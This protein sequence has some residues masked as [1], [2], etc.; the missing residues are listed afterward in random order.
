MVYWID[1]SKDPRW[2]EFVNRHESSSVFHTPEWLRALQRTYGFTPLAITTSPPG[3]D[4]EDGIPFCRVRSFL[5]GTR[6]VSL[7]FTDHCQPL[8]APEEILQALPEHCRREKLKYVELRPLTA[9]DTSG[10]TASQRYYYH[11]LDLRPALNDIL[12]RFHANCVRRKIRRAQR[13]NL[14][15]DAGRSEELIEDFFALQVTTRRRLGL[16]PQPREWFRNLM[17][18]MGEKATIR[19]ARSYGRPIAAILTLRHRRTA[20]Y[21]YGCSLVTDN[22]R[23][24]M[25]LLL[26]KAIEEARL[27]GMEEMDLGRCDIEDKG[28]AE[29]KERW[30]AEKR[31]MSYFRYPAQRHNAPRRS[32]LIAALPKPLL[33]A[34]GRILYR[35][36]A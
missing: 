15:A 33:T 17:A 28:L 30:G 26:W 2:A 18:E 5:T 16:P 24:G 1:P 19:I 22:N 14:T 23:G 25:Q 8:S 34:A 31:E 29:F 13:E 3:N 11:V 21:K 32:A 6:L 4:L 9:P 35:H 12:H 27:Q 36:F 20:V 7:P 10:L